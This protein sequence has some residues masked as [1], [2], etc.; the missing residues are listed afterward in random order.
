MWCCSLTHFFLAAACAEIELVKLFYRA[1]E[2]PDV[3]S[4]CDGDLRAD[5][6]TLCT[7]ANTTFARDEAAGMIV[8]TC[9]EVWMDDSGS[10]NDDNIDVKG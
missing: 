1:K 7:T 2:S 4:K 9:D 5:L 6:K 8:R 3:L 10:N